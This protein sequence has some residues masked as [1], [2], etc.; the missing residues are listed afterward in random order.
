[1]TAI[2]KMCIVY[3]AVAVR[4]P[5][6]GELIDMFEESESECQGN[7]DLLCSKFRKLFPKIYIG[8]PRRFYETVMRIVAPTRPS[9]RGASHLGGLQLSSIS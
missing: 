2:I 3:T 8:R 5:T 4:K 9:L 7:E 1:M 6:Y